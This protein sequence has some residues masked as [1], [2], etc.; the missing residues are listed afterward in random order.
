MVD[1]QG[2]ARCSLQDLVPGPDIRAVSSEPQLQREE[3]MQE[4]SLGSQINRADVLTSSVTVGQT[5]DGGPQLQLLAGTGWESE[6]SA[7]A[8]E[9]GKQQPSDQFQP[10]KLINGASRSALARFHRPS[11]RWGR[12]RTSNREQALT[13]P[14]LI[15][16]GSS[17]SSASRGSAL[18]SMCSTCT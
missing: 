4:K 6:S 15:L 9:S 18:C 12:D 17:R 1:T 3:Q 8:S 2:L 16:G 7:S 14:V 5:H 10:E 13:F 11:R